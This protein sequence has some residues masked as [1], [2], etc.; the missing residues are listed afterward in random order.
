MAQPPFKEMKFA[1]R[2]AYFTAGRPIIQSGGLLSPGPADKDDLNSFERRGQAAAI[3]GALQNACDE[4]ELAYVRAVWLRPGTLSLT[5]NKQRVIRNRALRS[6]GLPVPTEEDTEALDIISAHV[7]TAM[8]LGFDVR[9][10]VGGM[11]RKFRGDGIGRASIRKDL[12]CDMNDVLE[13][14]R[15]ARDVL[16]AIDNSVRH[17]LTE[18]FHDKGWLATY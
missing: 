7:R 4:L 17:K 15:Q 9:R 3:L 8:G 1:V 13:Y 18:S 14:Y 6:E 5:A 12:R 16:T 11:V 10:G 2:W